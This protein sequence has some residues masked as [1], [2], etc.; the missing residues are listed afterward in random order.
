MKAWTIVLLASLLAVGAAACGDDGTSDETK[1]QQ[2]EELARQL[3][4]AGPEDVDF[5]L[6][7]MTDRV[8]EEFFGY[9][10][11]ACREQAAECIGDGRTVER[12]SNTTV[13]GDSGTTDITIADFGELRVTFVLDEGI[14]KV[15]RIEGV[16]PSIPE[17]VGRVDLTLDEFSFSF[18][19]AETS[20]GRFAFVVHNGGEQTHEAIII[21][22][23][24]GFDVEAALASDSEPAGVTDVAFGGPFPPG[25]DSAIVFDGDLQPGEYVLVCFVPDRDDPERTPH[26]MKGMWAKFMVGG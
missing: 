21:K 6:E 9:T 2:I 24:Q 12:V 19:A 15:D 16:P 3:P 13:S 17:G 26:A 5:F 20:G 1:R 7:H 4:A 22:V 11:D 18:D 8:L 23:P 10:R 14:W 25:S